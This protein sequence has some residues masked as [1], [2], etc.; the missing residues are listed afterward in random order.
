M[1]LI[2][3]K[4]SALAGRRITQGFVATITLTGIAG[5]VHQAA[6]A[7]ALLQQ[8]GKLAPVEDA[9][10][11]EGEA[12]QVMTIELQSEE[13][14]PV[15]MLK[16]PNGEVLT[17]NDDYGGTLNSTIVIELS[18]TGTYSAVASSFSGLGGS[19]QIEVRPSS[20]YEQVFSRA[21]NYSVSEDFADAVEAYSAAIT[22]DDTDPG[23]YLGR[24]ESRINLAYL[25]SEV[26][27]TN[28]SDLPQPI[29]EAVINDYQTAAD[30]LEQQGETASA[31]SLRQEAQF[32]MSAGQ[33][34]STANSP[35]ISPN[36][37]QDVSSDAPTAPIPVEPDGGIGNGA[38]PIPGEA[39]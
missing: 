2:R 11:F 28:P 31:A 16:G 38:T 18:E 8:E 32:F 19:Y 34:P 13:F 7:Q 9:Y 30:L 37:E 3:K 26:E 29:L 5:V 4:L 15:L 1:K 39:K 27:I 12:G 21:Y 22:L 35:S 36:P 24:A 14:D 20:E 33:S 6:W 10:S 25:T 23:A 17:S